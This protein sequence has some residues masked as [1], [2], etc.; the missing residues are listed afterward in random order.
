M[1]SPI[2][3]DDSAKV[4]ATLRA[5]RADIRFQNVGTSTIYIK[6]IPLSGII[7]SISAT[8]FEVQLISPPSANEEG[9]VFIT[10]SVCG[11]VAL[12]S[13]DGGSVSVYETVKI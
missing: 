6:K 12:S 7:P 1:P 5:N 2:T 4:I 11:F 8:D 9:E 10:N 3:V 13:K